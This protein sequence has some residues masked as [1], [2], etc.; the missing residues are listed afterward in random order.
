M[1]VAANL[2]DGKRAT[3]DAQ[4]GDLAGGGATGL[5]EERPMSRLPVPGS[6]RRHLLRDQDAVNVQRLGLGADLVA[7][8]EVVPV[9]VGE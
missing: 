2:I 6:H 3:K 4:L 1:H 5:G 8:A 9:G 7:G